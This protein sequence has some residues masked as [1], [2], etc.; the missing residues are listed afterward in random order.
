MQRDE[1]QGEDEGRTRGPEGG[2]RLSARE[3]SAARVVA[4][5]RRRAEDLPH[6]F[7]WNR[8]H[9]QSAAN[10]ERLA[11][12]ENRHRGQR[13]FILGNGPSLAKMDLRP[14]RDEWTFGLN[15]VYLLHEQMGFS[16]SYYCASNEL[17]LEQFAD[18]ISALEMPRF[19]NWN[20][21][22]RFDEADPSILYVRQAL[23][24]AD[25]FGHDLTRPVCSGG[26]VTYLA[27]QVAFFMGFHQVILIGVDH[28]FVDQGTPNREEVRVQARDANHFHPDYFPRGSRWQLPD[29]LRSESA[30]HLA[31]QAYGAAGREIIDATVGGSLQ[32]FE[33]VPYESLVEGVGSPV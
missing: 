11:D 24:L 31:R 10:R 28:D 18:D 4:A 14:L 32:V 7:A 9:G 15:R 3:L 19:L 33:K 12:F 17:V 22:E 21:R 6:R 27:M 26:T 2:A 13:C 5:L 29:L 25:F 1:G 16:P 8:P 20:A 23:S 30:Y